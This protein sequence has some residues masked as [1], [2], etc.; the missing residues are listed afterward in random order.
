[1]ELDL[2]WS[3]TGTTCGG[4]SGSLGY[5]SLRALHQLFNGNLITSPSHPLLKK[6]ILEGIVALNSAVPED[7]IFSDKTGPSKYDAAEEILEWKQQN[8]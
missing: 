7:L 3:G 5:G 8:P 4:N 6:K 1:M 2:L